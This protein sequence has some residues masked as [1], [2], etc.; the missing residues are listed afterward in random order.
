[1][2]AYLL[3]LQRRIVGA[4]EAADGTPFA[5]DA[6]T[7]PAGGGLEGD[8][9][10]RLVEEGG[11]SSAAA[12]ISATSAG[13]RCPR[14]R[15][16][17]VRTLAGAPFEAMGVSLVFHPRNPYVPTAHMNVRMLAASPAGGEA[18]T[19]FGGGMDLTPYY[20]FE[21][22][23]RHFH[24]TCRDALAP[25]GDDKYLRF[26]RWCDEYFFLK[27]RNE[28]A[29]R[30][31]VLRRLLRRR[32]RRQLRDDAGGRRRVHRGVAADSRAPPR[33]LPTASASATSRPTA[34]GAT[35]SSTWCGTAAR[36]SAC[37]R[38]GAPRRS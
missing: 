26:K 21:E 15:R 31:R 6:W 34:A 24:V 3:D 28:P 22:D 27:H 9:I 4:A 13:A 14:R 7:R 37:S 2:R 12:A 23:A 33:L 35:S 17:T 19:W 25:F 11:F 29:A 36:C 38:A 10:T 16:S 1:M 32:L 5:T 8:G 18:V 30:R 20:G